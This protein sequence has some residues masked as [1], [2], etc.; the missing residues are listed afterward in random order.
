M[1]A[2]ISSRKNGASLDCRVLTAGKL[3]R[4]SNLLCWLPLPPFKYPLCKSVIA[5]SCQNRFEDV[6]PSGFQVVKL[7]LTTAAEG[8]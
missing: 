6:S 7:W 8:V 1:Q 5:E 2:R 4:N 3:I